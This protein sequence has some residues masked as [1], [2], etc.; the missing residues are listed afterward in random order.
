M[1]ANPGIASSPS[2]L[3]GEGAGGWGADFS[4][5]LS[6]PDK[7]YMYCLWASRRLAPTNFAFG[8]EP[9]AS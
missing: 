4:A 2:L 3:V 9:S 7:P 5:I 6:V 1:C 8:G